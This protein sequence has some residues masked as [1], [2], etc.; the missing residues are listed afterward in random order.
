MDS[1]LIEARKASE[2]GKRPK[3]L[4]NPQIDQYTLRN[5]NVSSSKGDAF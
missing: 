2:L 3:D 5:M 1:P 4:E